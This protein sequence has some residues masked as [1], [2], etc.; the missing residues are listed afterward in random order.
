M[1]YDVISTGSSGNAVVLNNKILIDCGVS[2]KAVKDVVRNLKAVLLTHCH[3]DHLRPSTVRKLA[4]LRTDLI[5][6][7]CDWLVFDLIDCGVPAA[8]IHVVEFGKKNR[9]DGFSVCP[10]L[11]YHNVPQCGY[12]VYIDGER[13]FYATDTA[14]LEGITAKDYDLYL[15][16]SNYGEEEIQER[17]RAKMENGEYCYELGVP[18]RHL[19]REQ[20]DEFLLRSMG[21]GSVCVYLHEHIDKE[22]K[23]KNDRENAGLQFRLYHGKTK[24]H[25]GAEREEQGGKCL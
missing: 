21:A 9:F 22:A 3:V 13:A 19:S 4:S 6:I 10:V 15:I 18:D 16:E 2:F 1:K 5:F 25:A 11:L 17:I 23:C 24:R 7:C 12:R 14:H 8:N 20:A